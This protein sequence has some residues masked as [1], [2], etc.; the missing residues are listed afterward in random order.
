M[1]NKN[2][3]KNN[4]IFWIF[5]VVLLLIGVVQFSDFKGT[6]KTIDWNE[7]KT[8]LQSREVERIVIINK[9]RA[10]IIL[11]KEAYSKSK[12]AYFKEKIDEEAEEI[13]GPVPGIAPHDATGPIL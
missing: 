5:G 9:E 1:N 13:A 8:M 12:Y 10:N 11:T 6:P 7:L 3:Q 2:F 4:I